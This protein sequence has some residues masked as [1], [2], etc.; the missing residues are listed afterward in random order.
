MW[1]SA[2]CRNVCYSESERVCVRACV[3][4]L[5]DVWKDISLYTLFPENLLK[6]DIHVDMLDNFAFVEI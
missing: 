2:R 3:F 5:Y 6:R 1:R 4:G